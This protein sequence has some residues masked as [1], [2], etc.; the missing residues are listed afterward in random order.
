MNT[1]VHAVA[2]AIAAVAWPCINKTGSFLF[3]KYG[4]FIGAKAHKIQI[5]REISS[6]SESDTLAGGRKRKV[7]TQLAKPFS[8]QADG[9]HKD[10]APNF[11]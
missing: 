2:V 6:K 3:V 7:Q 1:S 9:S 10:K 5:S 8:C 4:Q 11:I